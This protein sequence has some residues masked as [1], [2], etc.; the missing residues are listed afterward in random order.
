M[1]TQPT[2]QEQKNWNAGNPD[3]QSYKVGNVGKYYKYKNFVS[4]IDNRNVL[5]EAPTSQT[6]F[7]PNKQLKPLGNFV[8]KAG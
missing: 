8:F 4:T 1:I 2:N 7:R 5:L 3:I 6:Q